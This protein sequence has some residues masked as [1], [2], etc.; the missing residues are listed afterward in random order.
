MSFFLMKSQMMRVISSPSIST[1]GFATLIFAIAQGP[2]DWSRKR[3]RLGRRARRSYG[4]GAAVSQAAADAPLHGYAGASSQSRGN[5]LGPHAGPNPDV[6]QCPAQEPT[7]ARA[8][9]T[10]AA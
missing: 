10:P 8:G 5:R 3:T 6:R 7:I 4:A 1:T 9:S 2:L